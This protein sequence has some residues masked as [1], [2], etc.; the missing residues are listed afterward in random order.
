MMTRKDYIKTAEI[1]NMFK[2]EMNKETFE[3]LVYE[4]SVFFSDDNPRFDDAKFWD[5]C[6]KEYEVA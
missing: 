4:F 6:E 1:I 3:S 5:A 2:D